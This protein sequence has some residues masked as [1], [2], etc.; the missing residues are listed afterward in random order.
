MHVVDEATQTVEAVGRPGNM[1]P[2]VMHL[3]LQAPLHR[4]IEPVPHQ[5]GAVLSVQRC[6]DVDADVLLLA[7]RTYLN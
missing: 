3:H 6:R 1:D 7:Y 4:P 2:L 5:E